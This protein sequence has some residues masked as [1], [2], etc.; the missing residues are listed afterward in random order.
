MDYYYEVVPQN[1]NLPFRA[2]RADNHK[3][4][5]FPPHWHTDIEMLYVISGHLTV[6]INGENC[7][8]YAEEFV[9]IHP[10]HIHSILSDDQTSAYM[11][12]ISSDLFKEIFNEDQELL[13]NLPLTPNTVPVIKNTFLYCLKNLCEAPLPPLKYQYLH[14]KS[15]IY[16]LLYLLTQY[17]HQNIT[18]TS[19]PDNNSFQRLQAI[20]EYLNLNFQEDLSLSAVAAKYNLAPAYLSRFF[21]KYMGMNF[22]SYLEMLRMDYAYEMLH[23]T[24]LPVLRICEDAGFKNYPVFVKKF[25]GK[26]GCTPHESRKR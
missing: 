26:Y 8:L 11:I 16:E 19:I 2:T 3:N 25:K 18:T 15:L 13:F 21:K 6:T 12:Q 24:S 14:Q 17:F 7:H 5:F 4:S 10:N 23:R 9:L 1:P 20:A 22:S